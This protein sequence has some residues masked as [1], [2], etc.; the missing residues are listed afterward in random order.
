MA[1]TPMSF[2]HFECNRV[3]AGFEVLS[4]REVPDIQKQW[5]D[6]NEILSGGP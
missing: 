2:G 3:K 4:V 6:M 1:K 5:F